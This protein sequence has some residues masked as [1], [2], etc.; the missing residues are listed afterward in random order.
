MIGVSMQNRSSNPQRRSAVTATRRVAEALEGGTL[1]SG[2]PT[3][4][5][6]SLLSFQLGE[7]NLR[8]RIGDQGAALDTQ[9]DDPDV[10]VVL[11][12]QLWSEFATLPPRPLFRSLNALIAHG[13]DLVAG[14]AL[15]RA[16]HAVHID[17]VLDCARGFGDN[18]LPRPRTARTAIGRYIE[19]SIGGTERT[20]YYESS[21]TGPPLLCLHTA[22]SDSRQYEFVLEDSDIQSQWTVI[23]FDLPG[24]GRSSAPVNWQR[25]NY[26][27]HLEDYV[28]LTLA[29]MD[30]LG[31]E[32][33]ALLGCSMGGSMALYLAATHGD[34]FRGVCSVGG[35]GGNPSRRNVWASHGQVDHS[36]F[37]QSW[38]GGLFA[39]V[40]PSAL[41]DEVLWHYAQGGPGVYYG[42]TNVGGNEL[43]AAWSQVH[44]TVT[45]PSYILSGE[46]DYSHKP[47]ES[48][49]LADRIGAH[50]EL[51]SGLG[52]F[53]VFEDPSRFL[54]YLKRVLDSL[55]R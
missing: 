43:A 19:V 18:R 7:E 38:V 30:A 42:D 28:E 36:R 45:C 44:G 31:L 3:T 15:I 16:Q 14:S 21:G 53:A 13:H 35:S 49:A 41:R 6:S 9:D 52:H 54:P 5:G 48:Q 26:E 55:P 32:Q 23:A 34:R 4:T 29:F 50:F 39:P 17:R 22:G 25:E 8:I 27:L 37:I 11:T 10:T 33:P 20:I 47:E 51:M 40:S 46:Y 24:H 1:F 2:I 12:P